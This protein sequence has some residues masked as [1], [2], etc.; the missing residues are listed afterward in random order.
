VANN[1]IKL[2]DP[3]GMEVVLSGDAASVE[4]TYNQIA[5]GANAFGVSVTKNDQ[6]VLSATY[7]GKEEISKDR[8]LI[9]DAINSTEVQ[10]QMRCAEAHGIT[11]PD[12]RSVPMFG[13]VFAGNRENTDKSKSFSVI[14]DLI[15]NPSDMKTFDNHYK[16]PGRGML[17]EMTESFIGGKNAISAGY[18][19]GTYGSNNPF[20]NEAQG[21]AIPQPGPGGFFSAN[22]KGHGVWSRPASQVIYNAGDGS[23][24]IFKKVKL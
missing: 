2:V 24:A 7:S 18:T 15:V 12:G 21:S 19:D 5:T 6:G 11:T 4:E 13:G 8:Q 22:D 3:N 20:Y 17:H 9:M 23:G 10:V 14:T 1:P 16:T